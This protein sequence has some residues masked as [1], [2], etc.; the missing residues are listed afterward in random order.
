MFGHACQNLLEFIT[1]NA[2]NFGYVNK[3]RQFCHIG[4]G[5]MRLS[6]TGFKDI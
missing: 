4:S 3:Y 1:K 6:F 2:R 5:K